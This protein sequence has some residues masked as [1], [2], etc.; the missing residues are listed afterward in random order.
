NSIDADGT[1][2]G[3]E[4]RLTRMIA[5][6]VPVPVVASGGAGKLADFYAVLTQGKADAALAAGVFHFG[7][8]TV[9]DVK[10]SLQAQGVAVRMDGVE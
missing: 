5:E 8:M 6:A 4:L 9:P 1:K 10:R 3:Y 2:A 7:E